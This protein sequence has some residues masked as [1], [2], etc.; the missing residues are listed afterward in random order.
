MGICGGGGG[1]GNGGGKPKG[2]KEKVGGETSIAI[3]SPEHQ[4]KTSFIKALSTLYHIQ[5]PHLQFLFSLTFKLQPDEKEGTTYIFDLVVDGKKEVIKI[6]I[7]DSKD[8][9]G[10]IIFVLFCTTSTFCGLD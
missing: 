3:I 8:M 10:I 5:V 4:G 7:T 6:L 9:L 1:G 2:G